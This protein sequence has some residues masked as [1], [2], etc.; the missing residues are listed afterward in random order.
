MGSLDNN[1]GAA[2]I[3][4]STSALAI[5]KYNQVIYLWTIY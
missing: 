3:K 1:T 4:G 5:G 2:T